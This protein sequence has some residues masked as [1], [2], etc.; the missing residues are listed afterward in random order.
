[1]EFSKK[2]IKN[3]IF[4]KNKNKKSGRE[5]IPLYIIRYIL[6]RFKIIIFKNSQNYNNFNISLFLFKKKKKKKKRKVG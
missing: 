1:M 5:I 2:K 6:H 4:F 3:Y